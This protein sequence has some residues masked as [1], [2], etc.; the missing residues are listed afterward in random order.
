MSVTIDL[1]G[2]VSLKTP[3]SFS[4]EK[5]TGNSDCLLQF[6]FSLCERRFSGAKYSTFNM[7][8]SLTFVGERGPAIYR[9]SI[10]ATWHGTGALAVHGDQP[11]L[12]LRFTQ[13]NIPIDGI[14]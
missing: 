9:S 5:P 8:S 12:S 4:V 7:S 6:S 14:F 2:H 3:K 1:Q 13:P 10:L 11:L